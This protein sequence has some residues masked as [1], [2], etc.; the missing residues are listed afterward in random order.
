MRRGT[1]PPQ[2]FTLPVEIPQGSLVRVIYAQ[3]QGEEKKVL[4][5]K[6]GND[7]Q[8][9]GKVVSTKLTQEETFMMDDTKM[10]FIQ[11]RVLT[12]DGD[13]PGFQ[14]L[15]VKPKECLEDVV[16]SFDGGAE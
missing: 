14:V 7:V 13:A 6:T 5:V 9:S 1:T 3:K 15:T 4:F 16:M 11:L 8:V 10:V 12:P 2:K